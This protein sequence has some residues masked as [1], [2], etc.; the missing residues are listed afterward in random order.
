MWSK[1]E[2][3]ANASGPIPSRWAG[4]AETG[5]GVTLVRASV[6]AVEGW[7]VLDSGSEV[8][9]LDRSF[10]D[11]LGIDPGRS[12]AVG[13]C[14]IQATLRRPNSFRFGSLRFDDPLFLVL[15]LGPFLEE[16]D[17]GSPVAGILG[18]PVLEHAVVE[19]LYDERDDQ[20]RV[21]PPD[22]IPAMSRPVRWTPSRWPEGR[23][24]VELTLD[25]TV[26]WYAVDTG[27]SGTLSV[28]SHFAEEHGLPGARPS[29][30]VENRRLCGISPERSVRMDVE[31][32]GR[33]LDSAEVRFRMPGTEAARSEGQA[34][35][36]VLG[37]EILKNFALLL[38]FPH[39]RVALI[40]R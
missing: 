40:L 30:I 27:K 5:E 25:G 33:R 22:A 10:A 21:Y 15:D 23:P 13:E 17:A 2:V 20:V 11:S 16:V 37:R 32:A 29:S 18:R 36:G 7:F 28:A 9:V 4:D 12:L 24:T 8:M 34:Y 26:G 6:D 14:D 3:T 31:V 39:R 19:V 1:S 35:A 38:D